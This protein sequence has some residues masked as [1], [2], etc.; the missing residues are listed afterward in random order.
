MVRRLLGAR[1]QG[2]RA[3]GPPPYG[4]SPA[5]GRANSLP[6]P[7]G[8]TDLRFEGSNRD[9]RRRRAGRPGGDAVLPAPLPGDGLVDQ[10]CLYR[11]IPR[12]VRHRRLAGA[13][14]RVETRL[15]AG[16]GPHASPRPAAGRY[17]EGGR[18]SSVPIARTI[19]REALVEGGRVVPAVVVATIASLAVFL[20]AQAILLLR[21]HH[22]TWESYAHLES[23]HFASQVVGSIWP[24]LL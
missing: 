12:P 3:P 24:D 17:P 16:R 14:R 19:E 15:A 23:P 20:A 1:A 13:A 10:P 11:C 9:H 4:S 2:G 7:R 5:I 18:V 21:A 6:P 22:L 8:G